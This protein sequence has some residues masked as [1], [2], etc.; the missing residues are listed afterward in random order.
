MYIRKEV[1]CILL[2]L[3]YFDLE[4]CIVGTEN[5]F[6]RTFTVDVLSKHDLSKCCEQS[7]V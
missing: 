6:K 1:F 2:I 7:V 3:T 4:T 5:G